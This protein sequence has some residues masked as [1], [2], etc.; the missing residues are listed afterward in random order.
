MITRIVSFG[1]R[2][3]GNIQVQIDPDKY[4][5]PTAEANHAEIF[6]RHF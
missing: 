3:D 2:Q 6:T 1:L 4:V 5:P